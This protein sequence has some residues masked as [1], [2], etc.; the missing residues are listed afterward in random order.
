MRFFFYILTAICIFIST[1]W[2]QEYSKSKYNYYPP[3]EKL[4]NKPGLTIMK[5]PAYQQTT[6]YTCGPATLLTLANHFYPDDYPKS[7]NIEMQI[8]QEA[9]TRDM[10]HDFPGT[11]PDEM[12]QWLNNH[13]FKATLTF[14]KTGDGT[15]LLKLKGYIEGGTPV[16]VEWSDW[17]GHWVIAIGYDT[18]NTE[19][20][21][22]DII[23]FAD[24]YD[25]HD[26]AAD[27]Y[28]F[29]NAV[30]FYWMWYD[31]LFFGELTSRTMIVAMPIS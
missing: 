14:E 26:D 19:E 11:K 3:L 23:I 7:K 10:T 28:S 22:D 8:A 5:I 1:A 15:A 30:R 29:F 2:A 6:D 25:H 13:D 24:P 4:K 21:L 16:I 9:G 27:G 12:L 31:A 18:R 17:G 20:L